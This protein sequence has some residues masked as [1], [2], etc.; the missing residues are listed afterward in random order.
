MVNFCRFINSGDIR[1]YLCKMGYAFSAEEASWLVWQSKYTSLKE[2]HGAWNEIIN[3]MPDCEIAERLNTKARPS[4]HQFLRDLM[5]LDV[6][7]LES[8][9]RDGDSTV[10]SFKYRLE[11]ETEWETEDQHLYADFSQCFE[12]ALNECKD[13]SENSEIDGCRIRIQK[14][15]FDGTNSSIEAE[16][17]PDGEV[18]AILNYGICT[19]EECDLLHHGFGGMWFSFP[20]PFKK[21][22]ILVERACHASAPF[23]LES[24]ANTSEDVERCAWSGDSSDML[25]WGYFQMPDNGNIYHD[26]MHGYMDLEYCREEL[27]GVLCVLKA[28][29]SYL[30][31]EIDISLYSNAYYA[32]LAEEHARAMYPVGIT[33]D[34]LF[35][36]GLK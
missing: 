3:T 1:A 18:C 4:L 6:R 33:D 15:W 11:N 8:M 7:C 22:D 25:A 17:M 30:K 16:L 34:G 5:A 36:A 21:G 35:L 29:S 10:Y 2:K 20:I 28:L 24:V 27:T 9:K 32:I 13:Q 23:V 12:A 19:D 14:R 31:G 26:C